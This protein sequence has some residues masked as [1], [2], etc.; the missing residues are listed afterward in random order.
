MRYFVTGGAGFIGSN[1]VRMLLSGK[2]G[3]VSAVTVFDDL[4]Y[5]GNLSNLTGC[6]NDPRF[7]FVKGNIL[8][9]TIIR[10]NLESNQILVHFAAESHV[11]RSISHPSVFVETNILGT[12]NLLDI[13]LEKGVKLFLHVSTD[14]VYGSIPAGHSSEESNL[15]PN[16]PYAASKAAS[17]LIVRSYVK[18][19]GLDARITRCSNNYGPFQNREKF[20][21]TV[22]NS[23]FN[24]TKIPVY[25]AGINV[26]EWIHVDDH[27]YGIQLVIQLG[28]KGEIYNI[29]SEESHTNLEIIHLL[30]EELKIEDYEIT[31]VEDRKGHDQ[32]YSLDSRKIRT[33][34]KFNPIKNLKKSVI[35][36]AS[37]YSSMEPKS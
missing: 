37:Q 14:E 32:R 36:F 4:T 21:P 33:E 10:K 18:T 2:L 29:G 13:S 25:G 5:A 7:T 22:L 6:K 34:L 27:C 3:P 31:F 9:K 11:D 24:G 15:L 35:E 12:Q 19:Y 28:K 16:S 23:L 1:Y 8:E 20:I 17:D 30:A 26:R